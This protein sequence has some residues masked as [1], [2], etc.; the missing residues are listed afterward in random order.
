MTFRSECSTDRMDQNDSDAPSST[1]TK[2]ASDG[3][4]MLASDGRHKGG[5]PPF[6]FPFNGWA[7]AL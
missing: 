1:A 4:H 7:S 3:R 6:S 5:S 2:L